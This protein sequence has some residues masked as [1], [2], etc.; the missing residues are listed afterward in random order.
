M[1]ILKVTA[2]GQGRRSHIA[3]VGIACVDCVYHHAA[4]LSTR[5]PYALH[6]D[7]GLALLLWDA[8]RHSLFARAASERA[9]TAD[10]ISCLDGADHAMDHA[11]EHETAIL[12]RCCAARSGVFPA[13][14]LFDFGC[15]CIH[16]YPLPQLVRYDPTPLIVAPK[17]A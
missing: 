3:H 7:S 8:L 4:L 5:E 15:H 6:T 14:G 12:R 16:D 17:D 13:S 1:E 11:M 2:H 10:G 9:E